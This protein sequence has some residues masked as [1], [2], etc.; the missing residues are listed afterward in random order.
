MHM[1]GAADSV[2]KLSN[3]V[4]WQHVIEEGEAPGTGRGHYGQA[5]WSA[6]E[7]VC[8][9]SCGAMPFSARKHAGVMKPSLIAALADVGASQNHAVTYRERYVASADG[10]SA[11]P[12]RFAS[13][14]DAVSSLGGPA[15][16]LQ[17][18]SGLSHA[19]RTCM[20]RDALH[21][22]RGVSAR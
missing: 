10:G 12:D 18:Q 3:V 4:S 13:H 16:K 5:R 8:A 11:A 21:A 14:L 17:R 7:Q 9:G 15:T 20:S 6:G 22:G 19:M 2:C 1:H